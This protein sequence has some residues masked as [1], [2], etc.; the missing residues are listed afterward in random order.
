MCCSLCHRDCLLSGH[1]SG[2]GHDRLWAHL[3]EQGWI[4][5]AIRTPEGTASHY[6]GRPSSCRGRTVG[7]PPASAH[8]APS[9]ARSMITFGASSVPYM[10][11]TAFS[12][13]LNVPGTGATGNPPTNPRTVIP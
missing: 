10:R 3:N 4:G 11:M 8:P 6:L 13:S 1:S 12:T 9:L 7:V 5:R 2:I